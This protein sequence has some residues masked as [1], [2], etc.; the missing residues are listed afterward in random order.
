MDIPTLIMWVLVLA[1]V[2]SMLWFGVSMVAGGKKGKRIKTVISRHRG[3]LSR[4]QVDDLKKTSAIRQTKEKPHVELIKKILGMV[5]LQHLLFSDEVRNQLAQAGLRGRGVVP[6]YVSTRILMTLGGAIGT[7][8][9][10]GLM[11]KFPYPDFVKFIFAAAGAAAGFYMP[12]L[13]LANTVQKRQDEM[14]KGFP[15][16]LDLLVIC[17]ESGLGIEAAFTR[18]TDEI[19]ENAPVLAQEL[20]LMSAELAYL[21]DRRQAYENFS[22]RTGLASA[23]ALATALIQ[24]EQYG[25]PIGVAIK[26][27]AQEKRDE[28]MSNAE[29]K[30][31]ALPAKLTVPMIIFFLP[32]L[33]IVVIGPAYL[34]IVGGG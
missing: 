8:I 33:F 13:L 6:A 29:K 34:S 5:N 1:G 26:V 2:G 30:A 21:G 25:T 18:V 24:S 17:V 10:I 11:E 23:K 20:G 32:C 14:T 12:K 7:L 15:D 16:T 31:A 27:L 9:F 19:A 4:R 28:R 22:N 3:E